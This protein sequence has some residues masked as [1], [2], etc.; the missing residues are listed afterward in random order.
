MQ[1]SGHVECKTNPSGVEPERVVE[2]SN[3]ER[4]RIFEEKKM[5]KA[6]CGEVRK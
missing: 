5:C 2:N 1:L 6:I 4:E 3:R